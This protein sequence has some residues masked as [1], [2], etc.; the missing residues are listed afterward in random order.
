MVRRVRFLR[1][2]FWSGHDQY[3]KG[4]DGKKYLKVPRNTSKYPEVHLSNQKY[5]KVLKGTSK[6]PKV[7]QSNLK[8]LKVPRSTSKYPNLPE[9]HMVFSG[10]FRA[11]WNSLEHVGTLRAIC[12]DGMGL[13]SLNSLPIR[14]IAER[15]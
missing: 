3:W 13:L 11:V 8:Y 10:Q 14:V 1:V 6:Y 4:L 12:Q 2:H 5:L 9:H 7:S 15:C